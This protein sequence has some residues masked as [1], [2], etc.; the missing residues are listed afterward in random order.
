[1]HIRL[2]WVQFIQSHL[3]C[4]YATELKSIVNIEVGMKMQGM[5][6]GTI[7]GINFFHLPGHPHNTNCL[8]EAGVAS[9]DAISLDP[10]KI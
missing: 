10:R 3:I 1:M 9:A 6:T 4:R 8:E 2:A 5:P 7:D